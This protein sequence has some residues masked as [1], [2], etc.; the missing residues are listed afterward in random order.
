[1]PIFIKDDE[2][3]KNSELSE[4]LKQ[5][6]LNIRKERTLLMDQLRKESPGK[7][8]KVVEKVAQGGLGCTTL[9]AGQKAFVTR[10][11]K[12]SKEEFN[13]LSVETVKKFNAYCK[14]R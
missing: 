5:T 1:M 7:F 14:V 8:V 6:V 9:S 11:S 13:K 12:L 3:V 2:D 10:I 4:E